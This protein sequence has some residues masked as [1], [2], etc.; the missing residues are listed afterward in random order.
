[1]KNPEKTSSHENRRYYRINDVVMLRYRVID[2]SRSLVMDTDHT[3]SEAGVSSGALLE[4]IDREL[5]QSLNAVWQ[6]SAAVA[7]ALGLLNRKLSVIAAEALEYEETGAH[8]YEDAMVNISG[9]GIAFGVKVFLEKDTRLQLHL[10]LRPSQTT[11]AIRGTV[12]GC[13]KRLTS[14][15]TPYWARVNFDKDPQAQ[16]TLIQHVVKKQRTQLSSGV[17]RESRR[18]MDA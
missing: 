18:P 12:V 1:M 3:V 13:D 11:L 6:E 10:I 2:R 7:Q 5:G 15:K 14:A 9:C 4:E 16:E 8:S 17:L